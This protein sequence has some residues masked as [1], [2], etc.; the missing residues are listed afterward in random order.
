MIKINE[1]FHSIQ[2]ESTYA[3]LP[4]V[5][6]RTSGCHLRCD[7]CDTQYA[8]QEGSNFSVSDLLQKIK[9]YN[10]KHVCIT[11]GEPLLQK[12]IYILMKELCDEDYIVSLETSGDIDCVS[13][14]P[15]VKKVIDVK[16]PDS[17]EPKAFNEKNLEFTDVNT[18]FKFIICSKKDFDWA[19]DF[20]QQY[21]NNKPSAVLFS[22]SYEVT[23]EKWLAEKIL[24]TKLNI[25]LNLQLH[26]KIWPEEKRG[27]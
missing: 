12:D 6:I 9:F 17:G 24:D 22:P 5:F 20:V 1:I 23:S 4:T 25:R 13:V 7:Y 26:K 19:V 27:V 8:Y 16:T 21:L 3:G 18:E 10:C 2:G 11:G 14:D 15:R